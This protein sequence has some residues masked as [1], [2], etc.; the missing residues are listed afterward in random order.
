M[1][2][3]LSLWRRVRKYVP[4]TP[5]VIG[6]CSDGLGPPTS[7]HPD[8]HE[9]WETPGGSPHVIHASL[10]SGLSPPPRASNGL[11]WLRESGPGPDVRVWA[12]SRVPRPRESAVVAS[13]GASTGAAAGRGPPRLL[14]VWVAR[15]P[16][17]RVG[18]RAWGRPR[19]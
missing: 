7:T 3:A 14:P 8:P 19:A 16:G 9:G 18:S 15:G 17:A 4:K 11:R 10:T 12:P 2:R 1:D 13:R 5:R 6:T